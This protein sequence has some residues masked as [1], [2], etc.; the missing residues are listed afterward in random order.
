M[1]AWYYD[2]GDISYMLCFEMCL[3][4]LKGQKPDTFH[5]LSQEDMLNLMD[6]AIGQNKTEHPTEK[7]FKIIHRLIRISSKVGDLI[8]D[9]FLGSETT[10][11]VAKRLRR[12]C[13]GSD[14]SE[15]Y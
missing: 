3:V 12:G 9:P 8:I 5:F 1:F 13:H 11:V 2:V 4:F 7:P 15:I 14:N 6:Y 10:M